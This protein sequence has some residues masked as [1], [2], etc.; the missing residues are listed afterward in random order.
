V[1]HVLVLACCFRAPLVEQLGDQVAV[2]GRLAEVSAQALEDR[3][4]GLQD[5]ST[6]LD[7]GVEEIAF[8]EVQFFTEGR[9]YHYASLSTKL[10]LCHQVKSVPDL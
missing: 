1:P 6:A 9:G 8:A 7:T 3:A 5:E 10:Y 2:S 4:R